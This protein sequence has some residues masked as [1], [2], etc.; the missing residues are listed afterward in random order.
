MHT[1]VIGDV[2]CLKSC[3]P[4]M[5]VT[6]VISDGTLNVSWFDG[7]KTAF[8]NFPS[9]AL[10]LATA[11]RD[12]INEDTKNLATEVGRKFREMGR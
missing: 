4:E 9:G 11:Q 5:T 8:A 10:E 2:V 1:F 3:S 6:A 12:R 7:R